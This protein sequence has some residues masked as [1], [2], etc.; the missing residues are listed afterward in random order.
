MKLAGVKSPKQS[1][2]NKVKASSTASHSQTKQP[3]NP[4][5][6]MITGSEN[7]EDLNSFMKQA[8]GDEIKLN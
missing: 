3:N 4:P 2:E 7:G 8:I 1:T 6:I 5:R